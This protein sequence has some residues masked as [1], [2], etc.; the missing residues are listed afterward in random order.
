M[1]REKYD[2]LNYDRKFSCK[3]TVMVGLD[4]FHGLTKTAKESLELVK[5]L[6]QE[7]KELRVKILELNIQLLLVK[8]ENK[9][10][11]KNNDSWKASPDT[12]ESF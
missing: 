12:L 5:A 6:N 1:T 10:F 2:S 7:N 4:E 11:K 8:E 3:N 9:T